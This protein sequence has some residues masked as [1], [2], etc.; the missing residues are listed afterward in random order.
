[1]NITIIGSGNVAWHLHRWFT[2]NHQVTTVNPRTFEGLTQQADIYLI[3][4]SD[5]AISNVASRLYDIIGPH[6][7]IVAHTAG[8]SPL[9]VIPNAF[10][11][12]GVLYPM[13][14]FTK[15][16]KLAEY[17]DIPIFI[18]GSDSFTQKRLSD[19][20]TTI[21]SHVVNLNSIQRRQMHL[22]AVFACNFVSYLYSLASDAMER[23]GVD[24]KLLKPLV[25]ET[26]RKNFTIP[27]REALT[28]PARRQD[29]PTIDRHLDMLASEPEAREVYSFITDMIIKHY[30][31]EP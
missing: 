2:P 29:T 18:E 16:V 7:G 23:A 1:M 28:G 13:Q 9:S 24:F 25:E 11:S 8:S 30:S 31:T 4:V 27:P 20:A 5:A 22:A 17:N 12:Y 15:D 21:S 6:S 10:R 26:L 19:F 3:A 14:T